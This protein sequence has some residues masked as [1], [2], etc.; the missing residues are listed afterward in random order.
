MKIKHLKRDQGTWDKKTCLWVDKDWKMG[1]GTRCCYELVA[2]DL[3]KKD[4]VN[5]E[6]GGKADERRWNI[7]MDI[8]LAIS[9]NNMRENL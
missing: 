2:E 7:G 6:D 4:N 1:E 5:G 9:L 8:H 3:E